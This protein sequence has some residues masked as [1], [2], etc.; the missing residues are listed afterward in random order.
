[1]SFILNVTKNIKIIFLFLYLCFYYGL[2]KNYAE[3]FSF[4]TYMLCMNKE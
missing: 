2:T 4:V 3:N 1:M